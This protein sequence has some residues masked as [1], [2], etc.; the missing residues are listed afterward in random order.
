MVRSSSS[1]HD[2]LHADVDV[3]EVPTSLSVRRRRRRLRRKICYF[4]LAINAGLLPGSLGQMMARSTCF[5]SPHFLV[6]FVRLFFIRPY[7]F[8]V[9]LRFLNLTRD[10]LVHFLGGLQYKVAVYARN[11]SANDWLSELHATYL[12]QII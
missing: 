12:P 2:D 11:S 7:M 10:L 9:Y 3:D 4:I 1:D 5:G 6:R 8:R